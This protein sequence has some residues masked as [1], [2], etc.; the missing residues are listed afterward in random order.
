MFQFSPVESSAIIGCRRVS[1]CDSF[2]A[3][4]GDRR[5]LGTRLLR[6]AF[7]WQRLNFGWGVKKVY[8][9]FLL[10]F[11]CSENTRTSPSKRLNPLRSV[12]SGDRSLPP[13]SS[14]CTLGV[15]ASCMCGSNSEFENKVDSDQKM[16]RTSVLS[17]RKCVIPRR[18]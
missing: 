12:W 16:A 1:Y 4:A 8:V 2:L 18:S 9:P 10:F 5:R 15:L 3:A 11:E 7:V 14:V 13:C 6:S 17:D